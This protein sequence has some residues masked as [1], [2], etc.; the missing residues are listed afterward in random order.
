MSNNIALLFF[1]YAQNAQGSHKNGN[2]I[3]GKDTCIMERWRM[4]FAEMRGKNRIFLHCRSPCE[5]IKKLVN[6]K[7]RA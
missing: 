4:H 3:R 1:D 7:R 6:A 2:E 5:C